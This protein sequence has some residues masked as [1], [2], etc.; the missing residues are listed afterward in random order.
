M[1]SSKFN[2]IAD[3]GGT[4]ARFALLEEGSQTPIETMNLV[5][6]HYSGP[7][8]AI[9]AYL[10]LKSQVKPRNAAIAVATAITDDNLKLTNNAWHFSIEETRKALDVAHL[11]VI[12][13]F[14]AL[15]L[16]VP[17]LSSDQCVKIGNGDEIVDGVKAVI[18]PGT[19]LG[20][21]AVIPHNGNW[22]P[23]ESEGGHV[24]YGPFN[25][26]E[27]QIIQKIKSEMD[28]V[29]A[30]TLVS[31]SGLSLLYKTIAKL[32]GVDVNTLDAEDVSVSAL[33]QSCPIA[34][35]AL[36]V[37]CEILGTVAGNL[38]LT[39]G[40]RGGVYIGGGIV[41]KNLDFFVSSNFQKRFEKHG[42]FTEY[43]SKIPINIITDEYPA[44]LGVAASLKSDYLKLG[45]N[46]FR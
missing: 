19:G 1:S 31:G 6:D 24:S 28:H 35:E 20:V 14:T 23:L 16:A 4:N 12:N 17:H 46:C 45:I 7:V 3:I 37:F 10:D 5:C 8:D 11:K 27:A 13:D 43:L 30:E 25:D 29:S 9:R 26:R 15:S 18:G 32:E 39:M 42:R 36:S 41:P 33:N 2:L 44:F 34:V 38:A 22:L 40:A 21:S